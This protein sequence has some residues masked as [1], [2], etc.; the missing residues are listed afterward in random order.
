MD[1]EHGKPVTAP[2]VMEQLHSLFSR[3]IADSTIWLCKFVGDA[4]SFHTWMA[5]SLQ[6]IYSRC[7]D[8]VIIAPFIYSYLVVRCMPRIVVELGSCLKLS[9]P[10]FNYIKNRPMHRVLAGRDENPFI[11]LLCLDTDNDSELI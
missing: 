11:Q 5:Q 2:V 9:E 8:K 7:G 1:A 10:V 4:L 6:C 3:Q